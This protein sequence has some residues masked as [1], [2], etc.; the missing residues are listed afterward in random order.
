MITEYLLST[1]NFSN[2]K[3]ET[4][5]KALGILIIRLF[6]MVPGQNPLRPAMGVGIGTIYRNIT[7]ENLPEIQEVI[8]S[9]I[10]TYLPPEFSN[11]QVSLKINEKK[12][13]VISI[14]LNGITYIYDTE[15]S[16]S[17]VKLSDIVQN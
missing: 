13:L 3:V 5:Q 17:P 4:G 9:Q 14:L 12:Y 11:A 7:N 8:E 10:A 6:M 1:N 16:D 15:D 2:P